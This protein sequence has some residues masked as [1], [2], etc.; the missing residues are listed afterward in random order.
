M[1]QILRAR[2]YIFQKRPLI[3]YSVYQRWTDMDGWMDGPGDCPA[4]LCPSLRGQKAHNVVIALTKRKKRKIP[5][6]FLSFLR[7]SR[8]ACVGVLSVL[9]EPACCH[10][11]EMGISGSFRLSPSRSLGRAERSF[12]SAKYSNRQTRDGNGIA[13]VDGGSERAQFTINVWC[14]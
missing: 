7:L 11:S 2:A 13:K 14:K 9:S 8:F 1:E 4:S 6:S 3:R 10:I 5:F 12:Q